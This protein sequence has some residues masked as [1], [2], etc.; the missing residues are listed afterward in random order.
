MTS[1][2]KWENNELAEKIVNSCLS[3]HTLEETK[4]GGWKRETM[5]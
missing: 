4:R 2:L 3:S 5:F 1:G